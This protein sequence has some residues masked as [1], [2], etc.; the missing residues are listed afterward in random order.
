MTNTRGLGVLGVLVAILAIVGAALWLLGDE[1][2]GAP[3]EVLIPRRTSGPG[4]TLPEG[5]TLPDRRPAEA[6][7]DALAVPPDA[8]ADAGVEEPEPAIYSGHV[9]DPDEQPVEGARLELYVH[10]GRDWRDS[11]PLGSAT[12][13]A[14]GA[15][16]IEL[17]VRP[18][19]DLLIY[20]QA[21][22]HGTLSM[23][24][25]HP[26]VEIPI[27]L[28]WVTT[29]SG[30]VRDA[31]TSTPVEGAEVFMS[32]NDKV[33]TAADGTFSLGGLV[34]G[35][36]SQLIAEHPDYARTEETF[37]VR[38]RD[39]LQL[40]LELAPGVAL[41]LPVID[42]Q[43]G[44]PLPGAEVR[45]YRG[46]PP[47]ATADDDGL[48]ALR[49]TEGEMRSFHVS[50]EGYASLGWTWSVKDP[51]PALPPELALAPLAFI[52]VRIESP[53]GSPI[54]G[55]ATGLRNEAI[56]FGEPEVPGDVREIHRL[57]GAARDHAPPG[58]ESDANGHV[59]RSVVPLETPYTLKTYGKGYAPSSSEPV[60]VSQPGDRVGVVIVCQLAA[61]VEG[62]VERNGEPRPYVQIEARR[63]DGS[64]LS[65]GYSDEDGR[66]RI[67]RLE[68]GEVQLTVEDSGD[69][70]QQA[71][72]TVEGGQ[73]YVQDFVWTEIEAPIRG[74]VLRADGSPARDVLVFARSEVKDTGDS[75]RT[76]DDGGFELAVTPGHVYEVTARDVQS[77][78]VEGVAPGAEDVEIVLPLMGTLAIQ[79]VDADTRQ[80]VRAERSH[81]FGRWL[82]WRKPG[83]ELF[84]PTHRAAVD[85]EGIA[86]LTLPVGDAELSIH[87][88]REGYA[89]R[90]VTLPVAT[91]ED[92]TPV[93]VLLQHTP[94]VQLRLRADPPRDEV[95]PDG[96][97]LFAL[98]DSERSLLRGPFPEQGGPSNHRINGVNMWME[99]FGMMERLLRVDA[100]GLVELRGLPSGRYTL[101][102]FGDDVRFD[103][104][105]FDLP[106]AGDEP[107]EV[108]W[109]LTGP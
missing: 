40:D 6:E 31:Q 59:L 35:W 97:L 33:V 44:A 92:P 38:E 27:Q 14:D 49:V 19:Q 15:F 29:V 67:D 5:R 37:L 66:Y 70:P 64:F 80:P 79:L 24:P 88:E 104:P 93:P 89:A 86:E 62:L 53:D 65:R 4:T 77:R 51:D 50:H 20:A 28:M 8:V 107:L 95:R 87:L 23:N 47:F 34:V 98:A 91:V 22:G 26:D 63:S 3:A 108:R 76:A 11:E 13:D 99:D 103:P 69:P 58:D 102:A 21:K 17:P 82:N 54:E 46:A 16:R 7:P 36:E 25:V 52:D 41:R 39:P 106:L 2:A 75:T 55:V 56:L 74:V 72:L 71:T 83:E 100:E 81:G 30:T 61:I 9:R 68:A 32:R 10:E 42:R 45:S 12:S 73:E 43:T 18:E 85:V 84:R 90:R 78:S 48:V 101:L 105:T 1:S 96:C 94:T 60:L 109:S 57:T